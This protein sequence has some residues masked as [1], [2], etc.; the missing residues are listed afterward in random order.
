V[1]ASRSRPPYRVLGVAVLVV[2]ALLVPA[3]Y[4]VTRTPAPLQVEGFVT[5]VRT[6]APLGVN[7]FDL[8]A[9]DGR[10]LTFQVGNLDL[11]GGFDAAHL[12]THQITL[13]PVIVTYHQDGSTLIATKLADGPPQPTLPP[14]VGPAPHS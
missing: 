8:L 13:Q 6:R 2:L 14:S 3:L 10:Q 4:L 5:N 9:G 11:S 7:S 12:V 1:L